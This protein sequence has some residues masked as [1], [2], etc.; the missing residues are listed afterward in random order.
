M[1]LS[2]ALSRKRNSGRPELSAVEWE[3]A[4]RALEN[5]KSDRQRMYEAM[6]GREPRPADAE[7]NAH[8]V[9]KQDLGGWVVMMLG[10][11]GRMAELRASDPQNEEWNG[12]AML[13]SH[14]CAGIL[15]PELSIQI[16]YNHF[17]R[18]LLKRSLNK[19]RGPTS[20]QVNNY[21]KIRIYIDAIVWATG[22]RR[23]IP[24]SQGG[25]YV[26]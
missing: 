13:L 5:A 19:L 8:H 25:Q 20:I 21:H 14:C 22:D 7:G 1:Q 12:W 24:L 11:I 6:I 3:E 18:A 15:G 26:V 17:G 2:I 16:L 4:E 10:I 23:L 9:S